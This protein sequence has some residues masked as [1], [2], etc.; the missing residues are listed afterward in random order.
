ML[1]TLA[2][3]GPP[4]VPLL[5]FPPTFTH[6]RF[7]RT[8]F[9][10][11]CRTS[12]SST[13][14]RP[15][16]YYSQ[17]SKLQLVASSSTRLL[18]ESHDRHVSLGRQCGLQPFCNKAC[19]RR[20]RCESVEQIEAIL[21]GVRV[22]AQKGRPL[23]SFLTVNV[24]RFFIV[25]LHAVRRLARILSKREYLPGASSNI[26]RS[27]LLGAA[28]F[29]LGLLKADLLGLQLLGQRVL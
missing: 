8:F 28:P 13:T 11:F 1:C 23:L 5:I 10:H 14:T 2:D 29:L 15:S 22:A 21:L 3:L 16:W 12:R 4:I 7:P 20:R 18:I 19:P 17:G 27:L 24:N 26:V 9:L 25:K 6:F